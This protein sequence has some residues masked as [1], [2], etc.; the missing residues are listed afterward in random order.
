MTTAAPQNYEGRKS[1]KPR[2]VFARFLRVGLFLL[3]I[4][5]GMA[6]TTMLGRALYQSSWGFTP[7]AAWFLCMLIVASFTAKATTRVTDAF[8]PLVAL[9]HLNLDFPK[10]APNR[11]KSAL[12]S[13][14]TANRERV[15]A[16]FRK[17]G[18]STD[19]QEAS[20]QVLQLVNELNRHDRRTRGHSERVRA[21]AD[22]IAEEM[23]V[24]KQDRSRLRW[25]AMLHDIGKLTVPAELLNKA[26]R[27]TEE[28][29]NILKGHPAAGEW[30]LETLR[31]WLG[32]WIQCAW[33]HHER[34]DGTGY[35][36]G[37]PGSQ[38]P[39][40]SRIVAVADAFEVMTASR[41]YKKPMSFDDAR[42]ELARCSG[43][44]FDPLV[45]RAFLRVGR[46]RTSIATGFL[47]SWVSHL[48]S[49]NSA[50]SGVV[51]SVVETA[52]STGTSLTAAIP[53]K[54]AAMAASTV[55]GAAVMA[56]G[57]SGI[58]P[59]MAP[60]P[61][62]TKLPEAMALVTL[63]E[64]DET[65]PGSTVLDIR[66]AP[67]GR[68]SLETKAELRAKSKSGKRIREKDRQ[69]V[70]E[71]L[72]GESRTPKTIE[73]ASST[74]ETQ[75]KRTGERITQTEVKEPAEP[76]PG[77]NPSQAGIP[78]SLPERQ[79]AT[80]GIGSTP[81]E[82]AIREVSDLEPVA[83][84][85][86]SVSGEVGTGGTSSNRQVG[87]G[88]QGS[89][90]I[91]PISLPSKSPLTNEQ[92]KSGAPAS[93]AA[94]VATPTAA[95]A[96][97]VVNPLR[98]TAT[99]TLSRAN[100]LPSVPRARVQP[101]LPPTTT[102]TTARPVL[103]GT[104]PSTTTTSPSPAS[105]QETP[106]SNAAGPTSSPE[107]TVRLTDRQAGSGAPAS[108]SPPLANSITERPPAA[109]PTTVGLN[110][111]IAT[112]A[113]SPVTVTTATTV[114]PV[115][116]QITTP[117]ST[118]SATRPPTTTIQ[119]TRTTLP[120]V[121]TTTK[122]ATS[123]TTTIPRT[124]TTTTTTTSTTLVPAKP[125]TTTTLQTTTTTTPTTTTT[126]ATTTT[127]ATTFPV[128]A[129]TTST[130]TSTTTTAPEPATTTSTTELPT[131]TTEPPTTTTTTTTT[132]TRPPDTPPTGCSGSEWGAKYY[133]SLDFVG[134]VSTGCESSVN[135]R[136]QFNNPNAELSSAF[137]AK[138]ERTLNFD[139][140]PVTFEAVADDGI[141]VE[142]DGF[143]VI[144]DW[145]QHY[146]STYQATTTPSA[147]NHVVSVFFNN[148]DAYAILRLSIFD[149]AGSGFQP[150]VP[151]SPKKIYNV[152]N[153]VANDGSGFNANGGTGG[154]N[155]SNLAFEGF[156]GL[157]VA[158]NGDLYV[159]SAKANAVV[160]VSKGVVSPVAG[161]G[162]QG[163][164]GD[165]GPATAA[166]LH[167]PKGIALFESGSVHRLFIA[168]SGNNRIRVLDLDTTT[169]SAY[170]GSG[171][172]GNSGDGGPVLDA[173]FS[174]LS[175]IAVDDSGFLYIADTGNHRVRKTYW[176]TAFNRLEVVTAVGGT[177]TTSRSGDS[178]PAFQLFDPVGLATFG[179]TNPRVYVADSG[180]NRVIEY[181]PASGSVFTIA[182]VE[183]ASIGVTAN[184]HFGELSSVFAPTDV[185]V[186]PNGDVVFIEND[187]SLIRRWVAGTGQ[188]QTV[189][190]QRGSSSSLG[191]NDLA[192]LA[193]LNSA[194][195]LA[196][197]G[198]SVFIASNGSNTGNPTIREIR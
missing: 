140:N 129:T 162:I 193:L 157:A 153:S 35:P 117:A 29:W 137:S 58:T 119:P 195:Q 39:L 161:N 30:R 125:S 175:D 171:I 55:Q 149:A 122:A 53:A 26:G 134:L 51:R 24:S 120:P 101:T 93:S 123:V 98:V 8:L 95:M 156:N 127:T 57:S 67:K 86:P 37:I 40:G 73:T 186:E 183:P 181:D 1:W 81:I 70:D 78:D 89:N 80:D 105:T 115:K 178:G 38:M 109:P 154:A 15:T 99:T 135:H 18:L 71:T 33:E 106:A 188:L 182:G 143:V 196:T 177:T 13:G 155:S 146:I 74:Y 83:V 65:V 160:K 54:L 87:L 167:S 110:V 22:V 34:F 75:Q 131:T 169:I 31:P 136:W 76:Q 42:A 194:Q 28:E 191:D 9:C 170:A 25:G 7:K 77:E 44:H 141:I 142:V 20:E 138:F 168:D 133:S 72:D 130:T 79:S 63:G 5:A 121:A 118:T 61:P 45:V 148:V 184:S 68:E 60:S 103:V 158:A 185:A 97:K 147:G 46:D 96:P 107:R 144:S 180:L 14:S 139:G 2:P 108:T 3:P 152:A 56:L 82:E 112:T 92:V 165:N 50:V 69:N 111:T 88:A 85:T 124:T 16:E 41:S 163:D 32:E 164:S 159:S 104:L 114:A 113:A 12:R 62:P 197:H 11:L 151:P 27:P 126:A 145:T 116:P 192:S 128:A 84:S 100:K 21:L 59:A 102:S 179:G 19:P 17:N 189:A 94:K 43:G 187:G 23:G 176:D 150:G 10:E 190:G 172:A 52:S 36:K 47:S 49:G 4:L 64:T 166:K 198:D 6:T 90:I 132:T 48:Q 66:S 173:T 174:G 91:E